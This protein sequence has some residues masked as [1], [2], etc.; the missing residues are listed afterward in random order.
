MDK[1]IVQ[2]TGIWKRALKLKQKKTGK[3]ESYEEG[4]MWCTAVIS[5]LRFFFHFALLPQ[6][7]WTLAM[8]AGAF[9]SCNLK[10]SESD[11]CREDMLGSLAMFITFCIA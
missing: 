2:Y 3:I 5:N 11:L 1:G 10:Y 6:K 8:L 4:E 7:P 9:G